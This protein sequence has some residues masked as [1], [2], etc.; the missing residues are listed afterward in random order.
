[1]RFNR[2]INSTIALALVSSVLAGCT[3]PLVYEVEKEAKNLTKDNQANMDAIRG[4]EKAPLVSKSPEVFAVGK[5]FTLKNDIVPES[6]RR[7]VTINREID[8]PGT[9]IDRISSLSGY[10]VYVVRTLTPS[11]AGG[12]SAQG[13]ANSEPV[14]LLANPFAGSTPT[15]GAATGMMMGQSAAS[16]FQPYTL[17][18]TGSVMGLL[19]TLT[20]RFG[21]YWKYKD[22]RIV[23]FETETRVFEMA[24]LPGDTVTSSQVGVEN[25][26]TS[27]SGA[28]GASTAAA[29]SSKQTTQINNTLQL[30][31]NI[32]ANVK[33]MLS[34]RGILSAAPSSGNITVTDVPENLGRI[35]EYLEAENRSLSRQVA[36]NIK[37]VTVEF[38]DTDSYGINWT[39]VRST[40]KNK[41]N[42]SF[43]SN[44]S[45]SSSV[46]N[47][48]VDIIS[49]NW[50]G[51]SALV[52]AISEKHKITNVTNYSSVTLNN[53]PVPVN[54]GT[55]RSY[56]AKVETTTDSNGNASVSL[57]P[58][59][60]QYGTNMNV[61][62]RVLNDGSVLMQ[63]AM[64]L[65]DMIG[66]FKTFGPAGNQ[67][68]LPEISNKT[69]LQ[70]A[71]L[72]SGETLV[73]AGFESTKS[74]TDRAG[75]GSA[76]LP[77]L[78]G[79]LAGGK[80]RESMVI[81]V[82]PVLLEADR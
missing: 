50:A 19:D 69:I 25:G 22:G 62:P 33:A 45:L 52:S 49:G 31:T 61:M 8:T 10:P 44:K 20:S 72:R 1:M 74:S 48:T 81:L 71:S 57:T 75:I 30:W 2:K 37:V 46:P 76:D 64:D 18:Y 36:L 34:R 60:V 12:A 66:D 78:G 11:A 42:L 80:R 58:G 79:S 39:A 17:T 56:L 67:I 13:G 77:Y 68:Q 7:T 55:Q 14:N 15:G 21:Y 16:T 70:R 41:Y 24:A 35:A 65:T 5:S 32:E 26:S 53:Q 40:L 9:L 4:Y 29:T 27:S 6:L 28:N 82:Q 43:A 38:N 59:S 23:L 54:I 3:T 73:L 51:S 63:F 47:M